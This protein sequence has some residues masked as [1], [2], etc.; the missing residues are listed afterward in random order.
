MT[1]TLCQ[2]RPTSWRQPT[3]RLSNT[4]ARTSSAT[5]S[6]VNAKAFRSDARANV[7]GS[8]AFAVATEVL[9]WADN[10]PQRSAEC[11]AQIDGFSAPALGPPVT[12]RDKDGRRSLAASGQRLGR[13]LGHQQTSASTCRTSFCAAVRH[14]CRLPSHGEAVVR[15]RSAISGWLGAVRKASTC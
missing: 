6:C 8:R 1:A 7:G 4:P 11:A 10:A 9:I 14:R 13:F 5:V 2:G 15:N 3:A 12:F